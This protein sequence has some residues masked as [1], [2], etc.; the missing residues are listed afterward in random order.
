[1]PI[2]PGDRLPDV[3]LRVMTDE[4]PKPVSSAEFFAGKTVALVGVPGAFTPTCH[5][6]HIPGF[7]KAADQLKAKGVASIAVISVNDPFVMAAWAKATGGEGQITYLADGSAEFAK[8]TGLDIDLSVAGLGVR[9]RRYSM[10]VK[11][12]VVEK[13][14]IE[15]A[16]GKVDVSGAEYL[17][18][19]L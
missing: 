13:I 9:N 1:M 12:G 17:A 16:P 15:E 19:Q 18:C 11:D 10:L 6:T 2:A 7:L 4:G 3:T 14:N 5:N 8:A